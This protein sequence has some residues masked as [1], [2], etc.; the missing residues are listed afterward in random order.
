MGFGKGLTD[1][2]AG[3][4]LDSPLQ[5]YCFNKAERCI[6]KKSP[7]EWNRRL[8]I[9]RNQVSCLARRIKVRLVLDKA[10]EAEENQDDNNDPYPP[11]ATEPLSVCQI[12]YTSLE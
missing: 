7:I 11:A 4:F 6:D 5:T 8:F 3:L 12:A 1:F 10:A 9:I 2:K